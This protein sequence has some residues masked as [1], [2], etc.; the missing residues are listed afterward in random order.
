MSKHKPIPKRMRLLL[1]EKYNHK[2]A[3]CGCNL[4]CRDMQVDHIKSVYANTDF[5]QV[6]TE[7]EMYSV[8]NLLP[9]CRQCNFYKSSMDLETFRKRL[10][11]TLMEN[12]QKTFQY[13]LALK[14][15]L[16]EEH[17]EPITFY[18]EQLKFPKEWSSL[19]FILC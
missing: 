7:E 16:I 17:I 13:S 18:F 3:Y 11:T 4:E 6:M 8:D 12:L 10:T 1:Y 19:E 5:K 14:Y 15:G 2:C 9:S